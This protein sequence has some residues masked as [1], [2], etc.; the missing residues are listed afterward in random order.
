MKTTLFKICLL[1]S[2]CALLHATAQAAPA[3]LDP[4]FGENGIVVADL[5]SAADLGGGLLLQP[6]G[7]ILLLGYAY[8][9]PEDPYAFTP[10][11]LR[12]TSGG[13][14]DSTFGANGILTLEA[15]R[16]SRTK[17]ALQ[18]D[19]KLIA[20]KSRF[21]NFA[22]ARYLTN[23]TPDLSFGADGAANLELYGDSSQTLADVVVQPNGKILAAGS[24]QLSGSNFID[25]FIARFNPDGSPD[26]AFVANG[27]II[28]D[29]TDFPNSRY[30]H[31]RALAV[32]PDGKI[33]A[34]G[35]MMDDE[36]NAQLSLVRLTSNGLP[37]KTA[38][39]TNGKGTTTIPLPGFRHASGAIAL[40][41]DGKFIVAGTIYDEEQ[42]LP[43]HATL[44]RFNANGS[45][46]ASFGGTGIVLADFGGGE[47]AADI[48][49]H[50]DGKIILVGNQLTGGVSKTLIARF[51]P[52][53]S[54]D[55]S[56]GEGGLLLGA[57]D[58]YGVG[59]ELQPD[60]KILAAGSAGGNALL[61]RYNV[62]VP[63]QSALFKSVGSYD[64]WILEAAEFKNYGRWQD[65]TGTT[66]LAG[67]DQRDRQYVS[68]LSF[69]T[70]SLP[71]NAGI[72]SA[73]LRLKLQ[74]LVGGDPLQTHGALTVSVNNRPFSGNIGL[75]LSD[76]NAPAAP[77]SAQDALAPQAEGWY[78]ADLG[79]VNL[80]FVNKAGVTQFR[81]EFSLDDDDD[82]RADY[83][84]FFS[85]NAAANQPE[86]IVEYYAP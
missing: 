35:D 30:N 72:I 2:A 46:D 11:I 63:T 7:K 17:I 62:P 32:Q 19:G 44:L 34:S 55:N 27:F 39:G 20:A 47:S 73:R 31:V 79:P 68:V 78:A 53:G 14:L 23:G 49:L 77:G 10:I 81:L 74:G 82:L 43:L 76:F 80:D 9:N 58:S 22:L 41:P 1:L 8:L 57:D 37:D 85:G 51:N 59:I 3:T 33:I 28:L 48:R 69:N 67:D 56:F 70:A 60:G 18:P 15:E 52:D 29:K 65:K 54:P 36:G 61:A 75:Q 21:G 4:T 64:G 25:Y 12:Y 42:S 40:Q 5:G 86:F 16:F 71:D 83:L 13:T 84:K 26:D 50:A 24:H 66:L 45:L 38:F 6:D